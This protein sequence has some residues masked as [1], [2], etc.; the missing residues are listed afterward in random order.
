MRVRNEG[1][2][3]DFL[4]RAPGNDADG[5]PAVHPIK[6]G[7]WYHVALVVDSAKR[8]AAMYVGGEKV[9]KIKM[10]A[11]FDNTTGR[12]PLV[13]G[14]DA[15]KRYRGFIDEVHLWLRP[16]SPEQVMTLARHWTLG[17]GGAQADIKKER[18]A[19]IADYKAR[20][21]RTTSW[22]NVGLPLQYAIITLLN[23]VEVPYQWDSSAKAIGG[24]AEKRIRIDLADIQAD[25]A[26]RRTLA[27]LKLTYE[28]DDAGVILRPQ[29]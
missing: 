20:L 21:T 12:H 29:K 9:Q 28:V 17:P 27:P 2:G 13:M 7:E 22:R 5:D 16:L 19:R 26:L 15:T 23:K 3:L 8:E 25:E 10:S 18:E 11:G 4:P 24:L 14:G 1:L 6:K